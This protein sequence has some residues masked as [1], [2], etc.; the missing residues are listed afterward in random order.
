MAKKKA[1]DP[2]SYWV[3]DAKTEAGLMYGL[4]CG[5][6][7]GLFSEHV[8]TKNLDIN[9]DQTIDLTCPN[10]NRGDTYHYA[11]VRKRKWR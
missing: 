5:L 1:S 7:S 9:R 2:K 3:I 10:C 6:C 11:P 8:E 4:R